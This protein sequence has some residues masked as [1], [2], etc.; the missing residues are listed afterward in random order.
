M[1]ISDLIKLLEALKEKHGDVRV[2]K[3]VC[4]HNEVQSWSEYEEIDDV[5]FGQGQFGKP[6]VILG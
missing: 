1:K 2:D 4:Q 3:R 5:A 6:G